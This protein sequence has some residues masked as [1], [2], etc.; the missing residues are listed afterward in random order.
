MQPPQDRAEFCTIKWTSNVL[1]K[2]QETKQL[3]N[4]QHINP[5][6][7]GWRKVPKIIFLSSFLAPNHGRLWTSTLSRWKRL[8]STE[9]SKCIQL[10]FTG[11]SEK[12]RASSLAGI[13]CQPNRLNVEENIS[14]QTHHGDEKK[15]QCVLITNWRSLDVPKWN[16]TRK[17]HCSQILP[18]KTCLEC[19]AILL[20]EAL[21]S[22]LE[23]RPIS[24]AGLCEQ[25]P[26]SATIYFHILCQSLYVAN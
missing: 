10:T 5:C 1:P 15:I 22:S 17:W 12:N 2:N 26:G 25:N 9:Y 3:F 19:P 4:V 7:E 8:Q 20:K 6:L 11:S 23:Q 14:F 18:A 16:E 21:R 13:K 24:E